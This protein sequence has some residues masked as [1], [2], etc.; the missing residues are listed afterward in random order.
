MTDGLGQLAH[1]KDGHALAYRKGG[2]ALVFKGSPRPITI[3]ISS[4]P[5]N[6]VCS[7]YACPHS[8]SFSVNC[9]W[10]L[11]Q[12]SELES[13]GE[14]ANRVLKVK[15]TEAP[16]QYSIEISG[17]SPCAAV[18]EDPPE[19]PYMW[20]EVSAGQRGARS[21]TSGTIGDI[22]M[23]KKIVVISV[24]ENGELLNLEVE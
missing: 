2:H 16:A 15:V 24:D 1:V 17:V 14:G 4:G 7:T 22:C 5:E 6:Y 19:I 20:A 3:Q 13:S 11:G 8:L 9:G 21:L 23:V 18:T 10:L 12:G